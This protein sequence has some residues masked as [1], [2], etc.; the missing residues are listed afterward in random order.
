MNYLKNKSILVAFSVL[1][2]IISCNSSKKMT[3]NQLVITDVTMEKITRGSAM[4][5]HIN[6][7][8]ITQEFTMDATK[9]EIQPKDWNK[10]KQLI[11][12]IDL[13]N[14]ENWEAPTQ[15]RLHDGARA[16]TIILNF[17]GTTYSSQ[18]FDE[19]NPPAQL[20]ALY[21]YLVSFEVQ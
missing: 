18:T 16:T 4:T 19:G 7:S 2:S 21:D 15:E 1:F 11:N 3:D 10:I 6:S 12:E 14:L 13:K 20:K 8:E 9:N 5:L 17:D